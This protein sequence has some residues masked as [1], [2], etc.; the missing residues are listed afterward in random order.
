M[1]KRGKG[2]RGTETHRMEEDDDEE[3]FA[4]IID[5]V[6]ASARSSPLCLRAVKLLPAHI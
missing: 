2:E 4:V 3:V 6:S 1:W 5:S